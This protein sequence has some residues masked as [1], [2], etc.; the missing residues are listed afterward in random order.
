MRVERSSLEAVKN[1]FITNKRK[2]EEEKKTYGIL[3]L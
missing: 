1:R 3:I 2:K